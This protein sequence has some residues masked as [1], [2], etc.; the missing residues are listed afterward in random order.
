MGRSIGAAARLATHLSASIDLRH[1]G[2]VDQGGVR[3][4]TAFRWPAYVASDR[5]LGWYGGDHR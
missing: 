3:N 5:E 4:G 1:S 2:S